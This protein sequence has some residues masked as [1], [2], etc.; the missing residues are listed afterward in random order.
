MEDNFFS[1]KLLYNFDFPALKD[2][3]YVEMNEKK[4]VLF[5]PEKSN[6]YVKDCITL[7]KKF[8]F[9]INDNLV[10]CSEWMPL[11][12]LHDYWRYKD[13]VDKC[14]HSYTYLSEQN[15]HSLHTYICREFNLYDTIVTDVKKQA[16]SVYC[17]E[18][19]YNT[20]V[21]LTLIHKEKTIEPNPL[22]FQLYIGNNLNFCTERDFNCLTNNNVYFIVNFFLSKLVK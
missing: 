10:F 20:S 15:F 2:T 7:H 14:L 3:G 16:Y 19:N 22:Q 1:E 9:H 11:Y 21:Q 6:N 8:Q 5:F 13:M 12:S 4:I 18:D 17:L